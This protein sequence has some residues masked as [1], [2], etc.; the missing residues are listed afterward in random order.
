MI[1]HNSL[2]TGLVS[3]THA[4]ILSRFV[5]HGAA[6][7]QFD[8]NDRYNRQRSFCTV[9]TDMNDIVIQS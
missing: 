1:T 6:R 9:Q 7:T 4:R 3:V 2:Q 5:V 8:I